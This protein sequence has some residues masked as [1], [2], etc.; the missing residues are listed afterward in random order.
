MKLKFD[1]ITLKNVLK[2][3]DRYFNYNLIY[4][5]LCI[6]NLPEF[7][8]AAIKFLEKVPIVIF[9]KDSTYLNNE[10]S[11]LE[12]IFK[13]IFIQASLEIEYILNVEHLIVLINLYKK[14]ENFKICKY[15]FYL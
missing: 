11:S 1:K 3:T 14:I 5:N 2:L 15:P 8:Y 7:S 6:N 13:D 10:S 12:E 9:T 4:K